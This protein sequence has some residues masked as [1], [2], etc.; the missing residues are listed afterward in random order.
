MEVE[1]SHS[2]PF[3][4]WGPRKAGG[5]IWVKSKDLRARDSRWKSQSSFKSLKPRSTSVWGQKMKIPIP[6]DWVNSFFPFVSV[7]FSPHTSKNI[8]FTQSDTQMAISSRNSLTDTAEIPTYSLNLSIFHC[9]NSISDTWSLKEKKFVYFS[10]QFQKVQSMAARIQDRKNV[11]GENTIVVIKQRERGEVENKKTPFS[12]TFPISHLFWPSPRSEQHR[13]L[14]THPW[15]NAVMTT[16]PWWPNHPPKV[17]SLNT[18][19]LENILDL[20]K[21]ASYPDVPS[22]SQEL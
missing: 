20:N 11:L 12:V 9:W 22:P 5:V 19:P 13:E 6:A 14:G 18:R 10:S 21:N 16:A 17:P 1:G 2:L 4:S 8:F 3:A 7:P 15:A